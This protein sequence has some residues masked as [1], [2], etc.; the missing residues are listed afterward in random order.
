MS[1]LK[2]VSILVAVILC[3]FTLSTIAQPYDKIPLNKKIMLA[4]ECY[5]KKDYYNALDWYQQAYDEKPDLDIAAKIAGLQAQLRDYGR[6]GR[7]YKRVVDKDKDKEYPEAIFAYGRMLKLDGKYDEAEQFFNLYIEQYPESPLTPLAKTELEGIKLAGTLKEEKRLIINTVGNG[8]NSRQSEAGP[9]LAQDGTLYYSSLNTDSL[10]YADAKEVPFL[11]IYTSKQDKGK[12]AKGTALPQDINKVGVNTGNTS[13][14]KDGM[15]MYFTRAKLE[16][17]DVIESAVY[18]AKKTESGWGAA[19]PVMGL[20][21]QYVI[22]HPAVGEL[23]GREVLFFVSNIPGGQGGDDIYYANIKE[24]NQVDFAVNLGPSINTIADERTPFYKDGKLYFSSMGW[25]GLG[26]FDIFSSDWNGSTWSKPTNIGKGYNTN[27]DDLYYTVNADGTKGFLV[28]NREGTRSI[29][30]RTCCDDIFSFEIEPLVFRLLTNVNVKQGKLKGARIEVAEMNNNTPSNVQ[31]FD[32]KD[33]VGYSINLQPNKFYRVI[34]VKDGYFPDTIEFKTVGLTESKDFK[35]TF[36]LEK[37]PPPEVEILTINQPIRLNN[38]YYDYNDDKILADA[39]PDLNKLLGLMKE[40]PTMI[41]ELSSHTDSR[42][43]AKYNQALSQRRANNA[44]A[45]LVAKGIDE[46]RI[47]PVGYG[48]KKLLNKC[49]AGVKCTEEEHK[50][51][52]RTEFKII[53]GPTTIT[54]TKQVVK[55]EK[56]IDLKEETVKSNRP[57]KVKTNDA[58][59]VFDPTLKPAQK[60]ETQPAKQAPKKAPAKPEA[61]K[62]EKKAETTKKED[63]KEAPAKATTSAPETKTAQPEEPAKPAEGPV[64][65]LD[66]NSINFGKI[67]KGAKPKRELIVTNTGNKDLVIES[68]SGCECTTIDWTRLPIKP[69]ETGKISIQYD[70]KDDKGKVEKSIEIFSNAIENLKVVKFNV[71]IIK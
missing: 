24:S 14:S 67:K 53:G 10:I 11:E 34:T 57:E 26:G 63:K 8:V 45:W 58:E 2:R 19:E 29:K 3:F 18:V 40:Y 27:V 39:E 7:V 38:I 42:G 6:A 49:K 1:I 50:F 4:E 66:R 31:I 28:S 36:T 65:K 52:R 56:N 35:A 15:R 12:W 69:G 54:I 60:E 33:S 5:A 9:I 22:R 51:N 48:S 21:T 17:N 55:G 16:G 47:K 46:K 41:I 37:I 43:A 61:K 13:F 20:D 30:S 25:P 64:L 59:D 71:E 44:K 23:Y 70:S 32:N 68:V 62:A